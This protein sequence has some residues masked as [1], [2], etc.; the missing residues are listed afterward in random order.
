MHEM[1]YLLMATER[2]I[3]VAQI[4]YFENQFEI[5]AVFYSAYPQKSKIHDHILVS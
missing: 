5:F 1:T 2:C 3:E 4:T